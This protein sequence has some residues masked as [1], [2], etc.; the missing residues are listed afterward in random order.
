M[1]VFRLADFVAYLPQFARENPGDIVA[2]VFV[3]VGILAA[4]R[5][6]SSDD[7]GAG[8]MFW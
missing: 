7:G 2:A 8:R 4:R 6:R 3:L 5:L 1:P